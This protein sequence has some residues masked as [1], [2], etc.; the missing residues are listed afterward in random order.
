MNN[1]RKVV[2]NACYGGFSLSLAAQKLYLEK[3]GH[4]PKLHKGKISWDEHRYIEEPYDFS[5]REL[6]RHDPLL[7]EVVEE[8]G[9][10]AYGDCAKL[11]IKEV[12]GLYRI[13]EYDGLETVVEKYEDWQ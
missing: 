3:K 5:S 13:D 1:T 7:V 8:L 6:V 12:K 2:Y 9:E 4:T 11:R 10:G